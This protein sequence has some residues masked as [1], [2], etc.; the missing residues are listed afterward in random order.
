MRPRVALYV[1]G[2]GPPGQNFYNDLFR[3]YGYESE[4]EAIQRLYLSGN[5]KEAE[6][7][8]PEE[9]LRATSMVGD[10]GRVRERIEAFRAAGVTCLD[11]ELPG[12]Q[13]GPGVVEKIR[14][15]ASD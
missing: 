2:M 4:A 11:I 3:R 15:W 13:A 6:A 8:I 14:D 10:E 1:G 7:L 9:F 5:K 12:R